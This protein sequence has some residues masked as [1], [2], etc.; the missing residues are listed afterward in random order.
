[1][2]R[3]ERS[4]VIR[5]AIH[6][7]ACECHGGSCRNDDWAIDFRAG[8][9]LD[10]EGVKMEIVKVKKLKKELILKYI[11]GVRKP[12]ITVQNGSLSS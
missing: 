6:E 4:E 3:D 11:D 10:V 2:D 1:M 7:A 12:E 5:G 8:D 9:T